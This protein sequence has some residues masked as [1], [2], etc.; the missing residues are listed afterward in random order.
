ML[1]FYAR[2]FILSM[3]LLEAIKKRLTEAT[4]FN[5]VSVEETS[6]FMERLVVLRS[7]CRAMGL[8]MSV[9]Q[10]D[11]MT[12]ALSSSI[13]YA[14]FVKALD[15]L[16]DRIYDELQT[17]VFY[18]VYHEKLRFYTLNAETRRMELNSLIEVFGQQ[19]LKSFRST[20]Y[21]LQEALSCHI[22][23]RSTA[24]VFHLMRVLERGLQ[25]LADNFGVPSDHA[26]WHNII[27]GIEK[28]IRN[29]GSDVLNRPSDW[30]DQQEFYSQAASHF[31]F[32]KDAWRNYTA[33]ARG[34]YTD[35]RADEIFRNV[36][37]FMQKL[38][39]RL[40]ETV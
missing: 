6:F 4:V 23:S 17:H 30:K 16:R 29:I 13:D 18:A 32:V 3:E 8:S 33:H 37:G 31:M 7:H 9:V 20:A 12:S 28:A 22:C 27:E 35:E 2:D 36:Q 15:A 5:Q 34:S 21:D 24:C 40:A 39:T 38:S 10:I 26:N 1:D 11:R 14:D 25:V 19:V